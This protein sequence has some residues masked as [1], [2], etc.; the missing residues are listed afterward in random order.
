MFIIQWLIKKVPV[1]ILDKVPFISTETTFSLTVTPPVQQ[2]MKNLKERT[3]N[4]DETEVLKTALGAYLWIVENLEDGKEIIV[5]EKGEHKVRND[6]NRNERILSSA[7]ISELK[8]DLH[9][10]GN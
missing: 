1:S 2:V 5:V 3:T 7:D 10:T 6:I 9:L 4:D 8:A